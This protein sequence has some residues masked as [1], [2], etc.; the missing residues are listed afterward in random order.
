VSKNPPQTEKVAEI[1]R[2]SLLDSLVQYN[3]VRKFRHLLEPGGGHIIHPETKKITPIMHAIDHSRNWI[4]VNPDPNRPCGH[5][6]EIFNTLKF[7][8]SFCLECW[9]VV[10]KM[11]TVAHA[12]KV[13]QF[14]KDFTKDHMGKDRF[15]KLGQE[16]RN[17]VPYPFGGYFYCY[18]KEEGLKRHEEVVKGLGEALGKKN[19]KTFPH[20]WRKGYV[21]V[22]L[23]RYCTEME[24]N[25]GPSDEYERPAVA[26]GW[27]EAIEVAF[28]VE[29]ENAIQPAFLIQ[30]VL[31][32]WLEFAWDRGDPTATEFNNGEPFYTPTVSY[33]NKEG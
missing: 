21:E 12:M 6:L 9:K 8:H 24:L 29:K 16:D 22:I 20:A 26:D 30:D 2:P 4:F 31:F 17:W 32:R 14:E 7:I 27:E 23:K 10:V 11:P 5:F 25:L 19:V 33:H 15:C 3:V 1:P 13:W 28:D 18:G